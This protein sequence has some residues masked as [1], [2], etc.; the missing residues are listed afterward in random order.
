LDTYRRSFPGK[1][2]F[3]VTLD[4]DDFDPDVQRIA[5]RHVLE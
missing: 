3:D 1:P 2:Q 4:E 5:Q